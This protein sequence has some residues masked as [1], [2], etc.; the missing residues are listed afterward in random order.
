MRKTALSLAAVALNWITTG[1]HLIRTMF[2][3][4]YWPVAGVDLSL[5]ASAA[6]AVFVARRLAWRERV[7]AQAPESRPHRRARTSSVVGG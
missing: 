5:L 7:A 4:P 3:D 1:D 2:I 6:V